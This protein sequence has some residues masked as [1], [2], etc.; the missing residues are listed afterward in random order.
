MVDEFGGTSGIVTMEDIMEE[1]IGDIRDEF[2][3]E[4]SGNKKVDDNNYIFEGKTMIHDMCKMMRL[5]MDT[6]DKVKGESESVGGLVLE[7]AGEF[8]QVNDVINSGDFDFTVLEVNNNR[9]QAGE[10]N[11]KSKI[12]TGK[13]IS[14][15]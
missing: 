11:N 4:E 13:N 7:L 3:E 2:D 6:F 9:I 1:V 14:D 8:P 10:N 5:P 12:I 15:E